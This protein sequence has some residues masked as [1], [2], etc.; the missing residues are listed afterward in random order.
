LALGI[1]A[2]TIVFSVVNTVL[3]HPATYPRL[4]QLVVVWGLLPGTAERALAYPADF[5]AWRAQSGL[6]QDLAAVRQRE[7]TFTRS[8]ESST[9]AAEEVSS[10]YFH[11]LG[12]SPVLGRTFAQDEDTA[13]K[14]QVVVIGERLWR[15]LFAADPDVLGTSM[16]LNGSPYTIIG[17][18]PDANVWAGHQSELWIPLVINANFQ[19][20]YLRVLGRLRSPADKDRV[21]ERLQAV[22]EQTQISH[23]EIEGGR[24]IEVVSLRDELVQGFRSAILVLWAAVGLVLLISCT[25]VANILLARI[26]ARQREI[27]VCRALGA[28]RWEIVQQFVLEGIILAAIGGTLGLLIGEFGI[29]LVAKFG[30]ADVPRLSE[31]SLNG[32]VL[33]FSVA[34]S[35][36]TGIAFA[37]APALHATTLEVNGLLKEGSGSVTTS[38]SGNRLRSALVVSEVLL[39]MVLLVGAGL[40]INSFYRLQDRELGFDA[41]D[42]LTMRLNLPTSQYSE[43]SQKIGFFRDVSARLKAM[44]GISS[45]G[46]A[47]SLPVDRVLADTDVFVVG[48]PRPKGQVPKASLQVVGNGYFETMRIP[49][50]AGRLF[51]PQEQQEASQRVVINENLARKLFAGANP[52]GK[53]IILRDASGTPDE[54]IG[55]TGDITSTNPGTEPVPE[56]FYP[57][58]RLPF[59]AMVLLLRT[60]TAHPLDLSKSVVNQIHSVDPAQPVAEIAAMADLLAG[61]VARPRFSTALLS[62]FAFSALLLALIGIYGI[63]SYMVGQRTREIGIRM[64]LGASRSS[65][66]MAIMKKALSPVALGIIIGLAVSLV[67]TRFMSSLLFNLHSY[68]PATFTL[69]SVLL[70][71]AAVVAGYVPA[72]RATRIDPLRALRYE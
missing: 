27:A 7:L 41:H 36:V 6:F 1:G 60:S 68:D 70:F 66:V 54:V 57:Y 13:G 55:V 44:P 9:V 4:E 11:L 26:T 38:R 17:V 21:Q 64:A 67:L 10:N 37:L 22:T 56:V 33:A 51:S 61:S 30:P 69:V 72:R 59:P 29:A 39:A 50:K 28:G 34:L 14:E 46:I 5:E 48:D 31:L 19:A 47:A 20:R 2:N 42:L 8:G 49:L 15:K 62:L 24:T 35:F 71:S 25:N 45:V 58:P 32:Q 23:P 53:R 16:V 65:I 43:T 52:I 18:S 40:M 3:L 12:V 63:V